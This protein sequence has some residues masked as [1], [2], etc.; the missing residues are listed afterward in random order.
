MMSDDLVMTMVFGML[1]ALPAYAA[2]KGMRKWFEERG[3]ANKEPV[4]EK[5]AS[6][7]QV[8]E[9]WPDLLQ[10]V[11]AGGEVHMVQHD[12]VVAKLVPAE[13]VR[14]GMEQRLQSNQ[15]TA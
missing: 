10:W 6:M 14:T 13:P 1:A 2:S 15:K 12:K 5:T 3:P 9:R 4:S 8:A 11:S 7:Q